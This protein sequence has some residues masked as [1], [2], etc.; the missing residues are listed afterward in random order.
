MNNLCEHG[1]IPPQYS[2]LYSFIKVY[3]LYTSL[4]FTSIQHKYELQ[5]EKNHIIMIICNVE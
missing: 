2:F 5:W 4:Y 1:G 3:V